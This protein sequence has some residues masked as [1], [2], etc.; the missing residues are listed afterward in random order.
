M[1]TAADV[2][3]S[4][5]DAPRLLQSVVCIMAAK[6]RVLASKLLQF[7][8][9]AP[10]SRLRRLLARLVAVQ[11]RA[12]PVDPMQTRQIWI[13]QER[14]GQMCG[15]SRISAARSLQRL[16]AAGL[17]RTHARYVEVLDVEQLSA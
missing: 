17:I 2:L 4:G 14:L 6:Q 10:E 12:E 1:Y 7:S 9:E 11:Q 5:P 8:S 13:T 3:N 16:A 15:M